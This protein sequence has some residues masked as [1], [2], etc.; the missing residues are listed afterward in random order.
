MAERDADGAGGDPGERRAGVGPGGAAWDLRADR[1]E[2]AQ[3]GGCPH[4]HLPACRGRGLRRT[5]PSYPGHP[6]PPTVTCT[7]LEL[8]P[9][10]GPRAELA[11]IGTWLQRS[12]FPELAASTVPREAQE[13]AGHDCQELS[14]RVAAAQPRATSCLSLLIRFRGQNRRGINKLT[15]LALA[16]ET[17]PQRVDD[18]GLSGPPPDLRG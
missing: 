2:M 3:A 11:E 1:L 18:I 8:A 7:E 16:V 4:D 17:T 6:S 9:Q 15:T 13:H 5:L 10:P 14:G 12:A